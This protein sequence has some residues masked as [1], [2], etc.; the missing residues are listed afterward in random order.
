MIIIGFIDVYCVH[1]LIKLIQV[2]IGMLVHLLAC[3]FHG[4]N[5][6]GADNMTKTET[7]DIYVTRDEKIKTL[8]VCDKIGYGITLQFISF[9]KIVLMILK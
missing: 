9:M 4:L 1:Y 5:N 6:L 7:F 8:P 3:L 2:I